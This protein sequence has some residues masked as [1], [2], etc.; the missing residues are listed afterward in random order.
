MKLTR[1]LKEEWLQLLI[2]L[3]PFALI[4]TLWNSIP[5]RV[6][7]HWGFSGQ[8]NGYTTKGIGLFLPPFINIGVAALLL[9]LSKIDPKAYKMNLPSAVVKPF[10]LAITALVSFLLC[11]SVFTA[12]ST[13]LN[14]SSPINIAVAIFILFM[15]NYLPRLKPNYFIGVRTPWTLESP[16]NWR[17]THIF[18]SR[19][20]VIASIIYIILNFLLTEDFREYMFMVY[21]GVIIVPPFVYS[22]VIFHK[23]KRSE[24]GS[25]HEQ[26]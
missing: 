2:L 23:S 4:V 13:S 16:D 1:F 22:Y 25:M 12:H 26:A 5:E 11:L 6:P 20:W 15:G 14:I 24:S 9:W 17:L 21:I 8:A 3:A 19:L 10:R 7:S 18:A